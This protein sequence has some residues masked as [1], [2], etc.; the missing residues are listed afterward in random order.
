[1][2]RILLICVFMVFIDP[3]LACQFGRLAYDRVEELAA[4]DEALTS[5][6]LSEADRNV[7]RELRDKGA[8]TVRNLVCEAMMM[9][10]EGASHGDRERLA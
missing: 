9:G 8:G 6:S 3:A 1:M 10:S 2:V 4:I 5:R 7:I